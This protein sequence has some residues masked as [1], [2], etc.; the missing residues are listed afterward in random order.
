[1]N[2]GMFNAA[3]R[4]VRALLDEGSFM[5]IG[6]GAKSS[7]EDA[8]SDGV[9]TGYGNIKGAPVYVYCQ[10]SDAMNGTI[11]PMHAMKLMR[12]YELALKTGS[13]IVGMIDCAGMRLDD[14]NRVLNEFGKL[15]RA[16]GDTSGVVP[17]ISCIMGT[18]GGGMSIIPAMSD[19]VL[20]KNEGAR[21]FVN[22][23]DAIEG[24]TASG[25]DSS[26]AEFGMESG[27]VDFI[28]SEE[29]VIAMARELVSILPANYEDD[30]SYAEATDDPNRATPGLDQLKA[31]PHALIAQIVDDHRYIE[32]RPGYCG[33][34]ITAIARLDGTTVGFIANKDITD[35]N[36]PTALF[37]PQGAYKAAYFIRFCD[38]FSIPIIS[39]VNMPGFART[40]ESERKIAKASGRLIY[41][42]GAATTP[43]IS[44]VTGDAYGSAYLAMCSRPAGVDF[45]YA[46]ENAHIGMLAGVE[47]AKMV[48]QG[49]T[50]VNVSIL[51]QEYDDKY[52]SIESAEAAGLVD[53]VI[54][55]SETRK[56]L[57]GA[58][59][60][61]FS[62]RDVLPPKKHGSL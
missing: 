31:D 14:A 9:I 3:H 12:V 47:A 46:W 26:S 57:I 24:R 44:V 53:A 15:Y 8:P 7:V 22:S 50:G 49:H 41:N 42:Y 19:F 17:Q 29:E 1:M 38:A 25:L 39:L 54:P 28:G 51:A 33:E 32:R 52:N 40:L 5:E 13:P 48:N 58:L 34:I 56:Y 36:D 2:D 11:G 21:M 60:Q 59:R 55:A 30:T 18:C 62:K 43:K 10:D 35:D 20:M 23:P 16:V 61:L 6:G 4:R 27:I 37:T 45:V